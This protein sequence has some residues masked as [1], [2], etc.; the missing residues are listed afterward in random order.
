[1]IDRQRGARSSEAAPRVGCSG[2]SQRAPGAIFAQCFALRRLSQGTVPPRSLLCRR[3]LDLQ[4]RKRSII[5]AVSFVQC[6]QHVTSTAAA[7]GTVWI[8]GSM[9]V[10]CV[11]AGAAF[12]ARQIAR[13]KRRSVRRGDDTA[14]DAVRRCAFDDPF[15]FVIA[16]SSKHGRFIAERGASGLS[17][18]EPKRAIARSASS[19][20]ESLR[21]QRSRIEPHRATKSLRMNDASRGALSR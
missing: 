18:S 3:I 10:S 14:I 5:V 1:M 11:A 2:D 8:C 16:S 9:V 21:A 12:D 4:R 20:M 15:A 19:A 7:S 13:R 6:P 17:E